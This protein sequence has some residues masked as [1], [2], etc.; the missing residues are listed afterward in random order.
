VETFISYISIIVWI[1]LFMS[2]Y[3]R[4]FQ[5]SIQHAA[6]RVFRKLEP[7]LEPNT[8]LL[9]L[10]ETSADGG[11]PVCVEPE[12]CGWRPSDFESVR[13][14]SNHF[15]GLDGMENVVAG[16]PDH[17]ES[18]QLRRRRRANASAVLSALDR[19]RRVPK[20]KARFFPALAALASTTAV[21]IVP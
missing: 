9:G 10:I 7:D 18:I 13:E 21:A 15:L 3:Q 8:F 20:T 1:E 14:K 6:E 17:H 4:H 2:G 11:H 5:V 19:A 16:T 12:D